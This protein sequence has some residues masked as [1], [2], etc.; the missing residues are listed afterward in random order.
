M[1]SAARGAHI[2][3]SDR[4]RQCQTVTFCE[5][6][7]RETN[8]DTTKTDKVTRAENLRNTANCQRDKCPKKEI[9]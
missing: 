8:D 9:N 2:T 4:A 3:I 5:K 1:L 7:H 6:H